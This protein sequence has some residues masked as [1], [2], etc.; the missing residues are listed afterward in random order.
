MKTTWR[1][2]FVRGGVVLEFYELS[3][4]TLREE[5]RGGVFVDSPGG[6]RKLLL[7]L[8]NAK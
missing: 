8:I 7:T 5:F 2:R 3:A 1:V 6:W 4:F